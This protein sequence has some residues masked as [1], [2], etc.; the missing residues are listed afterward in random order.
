MIRL[1][2]FI[3]GCVGSAAARVLSSCGERGLLSSCGV[4]SPAAGNRGFSQA[5]GSG[6]FSPAAGSRGFSP[7][8]LQ[9]S[10]CRGFPSCGFWALGHSLSGCCPGSVA[11]QHVGPSGTR[12]RT[13]VSCV[14]RRILIHCATR[15]A[16]DRVPVLPSV[17]EANS[18]LD[19]HISRTGSQFRHTDA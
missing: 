11:L 13:H 3:L 15:E 6:G 19:A 18:E 14:G 1:S 10:C 5:A 7:A 12:D 8:F 9:F 16:P 4:R 2:H 17:G